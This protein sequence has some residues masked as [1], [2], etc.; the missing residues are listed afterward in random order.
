MVKTLLH[1]MRHDLLYSL[2]LPSVSPS[3]FFATHRYEPKSLGPTARM[4]NFMITLYAVSTS[5]G[6]NLPPV[7]ARQND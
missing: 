3:E 5:T 7:S 2:M 6:S 4:C 1:C